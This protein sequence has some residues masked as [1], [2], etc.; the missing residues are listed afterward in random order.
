M[1]NEKKNANNLISKSTN[2]DKNSDNSSIS[3]NKI[4]KPTLFKKNTQNSSINKKSI[5]QNDKKNNESPKII[6]SKNINHKY[7]EINDELYPGEDFIINPYENK[8]I[9]NI[10]EDTNSKENTN[11]DI[12]KRIQSTKIYPDKVYIN[13]FNIYK[14]PYIQTCFNNNNFNVKNE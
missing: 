1:I 10:K 13:N 8:K 7:D 2:F 6:N 11:S 5:F 14:T 9:K 12:V 3:A 4:Y